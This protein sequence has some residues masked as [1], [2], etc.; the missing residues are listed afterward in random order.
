MLK[1]SKMEYQI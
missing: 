1:D